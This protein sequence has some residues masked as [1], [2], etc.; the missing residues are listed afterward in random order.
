MASYQTSTGPRP[1]LI[2]EYNLPEGYI[3]TQ[4]L[5]VSEVM[6]KT[7]TI[8]YKGTPTADSAA[9]TGRV[10][11]VAPGVQKITAS[12][13][14][15]TTAEAI[16]RTQIAED[17]AKGFGG[18]EKADPIGAETAVRN[19][20]NAQEDAIV[21]IT[22]GSSVTPGATFD[23]GK[24]TLQVDAGWQ[25][26][27]RY[28][29]QRVMYASK[30]VFEGL[31]KSVISDSNYGPAFIRT[32][33]TGANLKF[34]Q[35]LDALAFWVGADR[36]LVGDTDRW[37]PSGYTGRFGLMK[38][39]PNPGPA[40]HKFKSMRGRTYVFLPDGNQPFEV[41]SYWN[42]G[43]LIN[44]YTARAWYNVVSLNSGAQYVIDGVPTT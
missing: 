32:I 20:Q 29:G 8:Y 44:E 2:K 31:I 40:E 26:I 30:R 3:G 17:E 7:G 21:A 15:Y 6:E 14:T 43:T 11:G 35:W 27:R 28:P 33:N 16:D 12:T 18:I 41:L 22:L 5:P 9:E 23:P 37:N 1:D 39:L 36:V 4:L 42:P 10:S 25:D 38:V 24:F 34:E 19:V 13:T